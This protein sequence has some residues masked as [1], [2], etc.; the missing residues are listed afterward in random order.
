[1]AK[2]KAIC[3]QNTNLPLEVLLLRLNQLLRGWT[4]YFRP[5]VSFAAF[6]CLRSYVWSRV[7]AWIRRK[8]HRMNWKELR[9]RY[10]NGGWWCLGCPVIGLACDGS[11]RSQR[12]LWPI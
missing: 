3:R 1:M 5:G 10:C 2:V 8:H 11:G 7:I 6:S 9:R 12:C 4:T